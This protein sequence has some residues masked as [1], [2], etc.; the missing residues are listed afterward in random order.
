M[1]QADLVLARGGIRVVGWSVRKNIIIIT[2]TIIIIIIIRIRIIIIFCGCECVLTDCLLNSLLVRH[3]PAKCIVLYKPSDPAKAKRVTIKSR[4]TAPY[5]NNATK[6]PPK[7]IALVS[8]N[9]SFFLDSGPPP[10]Q[11]CR[12]RF[13]PWSRPPK[14]WR[15]SLLY[16][17]WLVVW[18]ASCGKFKT[19]YFAY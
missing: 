19:Y 11:R 15:L 12:R 5:V 16:M 1:A 18:G 10:P 8:F 7:T 17:G 3:P 2:I 4:L 13:V 14:Q 9:T 6:I